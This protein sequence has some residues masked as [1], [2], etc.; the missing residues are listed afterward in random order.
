MIKRKQVEKEEEEEEEEEKGEVNRDSHWP[1]HASRCGL[2]VRERPAC[3]CAVV[4]ARL[5]CLEGVTSTRWPDL[6]CCWCQAEE[7]KGLGVQRWCG[8][9][10]A[11]LTQE[12]QLSC[13]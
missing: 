8:E 2:V 6:T 12:N 1:A 7:L 5:E 3:G 10:L 4:Q 13:E 9:N 11:I